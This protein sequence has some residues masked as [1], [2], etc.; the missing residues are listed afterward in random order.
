MNGF[1]PFLKK[2]ITQTLRTYKLLILVL[3]LVSFAVMS[4]A[5]ARFTPEILQLSGIEGMI[6]LPAPVALDSWIQFYSTTSQM[7]ILALMLIYG[8]ILSGE[9]SKGTLVLPLTHGLSRSAALLAKYLVSVGGW[10]VSLALAALV[11]HLY[12]LYLFPGEEV[13]F[14]LGGLASFWLCGVFLLSLVPLSSVLVKG[15]FG[16]LALPGG[17]LFTLLVLM[18]FPDLFSFNPLLLASSPLQVMAGVDEWTILLPALI[19]SAVTSAVAVAAAMV[20]FRRSS[21]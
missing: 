19:T 9:K 18:I 16:G 14:V 7:G 11:N 1:L 12:T 3:V 6:A 20:L 21:L 10:T 13:A 17:V 8:G 15:S 2:E 4:P 5:L